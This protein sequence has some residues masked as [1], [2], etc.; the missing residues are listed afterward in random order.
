[1]ASVTYLLKRVKVI[2][3][4]LQKCDLNWVQKK[5][6]IVLLCNDRIECFKIESE[7]LRTGYDDKIQV[8]DGCYYDI[9]QQRIGVEYGKRNI[10]I[11]CFSDTW[12][13][14]VNNL[15][16]NRVDYLI[17]FNDNHRWGQQKVNLANVLESLKRNDGNLVNFSQQIM[18]KKFCLQ[19]ISIL[20]YN[21]KIIPMI[22]GKFNN[23]NI[24]ND[25][26]F[27][28]GR[29][30]AIDFFLMF[31]KYDIIEGEIRQNRQRYLRKQQNK[32]MNNIRK[33]DIWRFF[34]P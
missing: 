12:S 8:Y 19:Y 21:A 2:V 7:I 22:L 15:I 6:F 34:L 11:I 33:N 3:K 5:P 10:V 27:L 32:I 20:F 26:C 1:M 13:K 4:F 14:K 28:I 9:M 25:I 31:T 17:S 29:Y 24:C 30:I 18:E 16:R 23:I